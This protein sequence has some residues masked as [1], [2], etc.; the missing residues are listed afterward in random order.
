[1]HDN[2]DFGYSSSPRTPSPYPLSS[3][4]GYGLSAMFMLGNYGY[5][6][7]H[8]GSTGGFWFVNPS[9]YSSYI[10]WMGDALEFGNSYATVSDAL[11]SFEDSSKFEVSRTNVLIETWGEIEMCGGHDAHVDW[12]DKIG[13]SSLMESDPQLCYATTYG[14]ERRIV[15]EAVDPRIDS[16]PKVIAKN[17]IL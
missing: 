2:S 11:S 5:L 8:A 1:M 7:G 10:A 15:E 17:L 6:F 14:Q 4:V 12:F 13:I 3:L 9:R 16:Y